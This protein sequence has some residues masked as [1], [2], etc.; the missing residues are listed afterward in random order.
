MS[1]TDAPEMIGG[2]PIDHVAGAVLYNAEQRVRGCSKPIRLV[3]STTR[4]DA[5]TGQVLSSYSSAQEVDGITYVRCGDRRAQ[6]CESCSR[7]Y[8]GDAW[9]LL[10]AGLA[11][12]EDKGVPTT[13]TDHPGVF[14]TLTAPSFGAVHGRRRGGLCCADPRRD[15]PVCEHG[16]PLYCLARHGHDDDRLGEPLCA[17]CYRYTDHVLWQWHAPEL[18][19]RYTQLLRTALARRAGLTGKAFKQRAR[20][21]YTKVVE[22]QA[23]GVIHVHVVV[24]LDGPEGPSSPPEVD[25]DADDIAAAIHEVA[26]VQ[27]LRP[28]C[29][30]GDRSGSTLEWGRPRWR[31]RIGC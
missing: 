6:R 4:I 27:R 1:T 19:R 15:R 28:G 9:H 14:A 5:T 25:L 8:K 7:E 11:G 2:L 17:D 30:R 21:A 29:G 16:R 20:L 12:N 22:F 3:G 31:R 10:Q 23:R 24:R 26:A 13:V 18:W